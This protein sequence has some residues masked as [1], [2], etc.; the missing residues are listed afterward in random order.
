[1]PSKHDTGK[2]HLRAVASGRFALHLDACNH[3]RLSSCGQIWRAAASNCAEYPSV[4]SD[5]HVIETYIVCDRGRDG[6][7]VENERAR[8]LGREGGTE[9]RETAMLNNLPQ[10][11]M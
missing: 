2:V 9:T 3:Q 8:A 6:G 10:E 11:Q 4:A 5:T 7:A 1:M